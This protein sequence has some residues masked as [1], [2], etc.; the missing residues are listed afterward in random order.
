MGV[1]TSS[2]AGEESRFVAS[3]TQGR[4]RFLCIHG[5]ASNSEITA[6]QVGN[7]KLSSFGVACDLFEAKN[8]TETARDTVLE[9][10]SDGP[11][12]SW[13]DVSAIDSSL[14]ESL[15]EIMAVIDQHGPY[16]GIYGFSLGGSVAACLCSPAVYSGMFGRAGPPVEKV[17]LACAGGS[18]HAAGLMVPVAGGEIVPVFPAS[19][20]LFV[21][22]LHLIGKRD[23]GK[24]DAESIRR[25]AFLCFCL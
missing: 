11:W 13:I 25:E 21:N 16:D 15:R 9:M 10:F 5:H 12:R 4:L 6:M 24:Y 2:E 18:S 22:S 3:E 20:R 17:I 7:L 23:G 8:L 14:F 1:N 19:G